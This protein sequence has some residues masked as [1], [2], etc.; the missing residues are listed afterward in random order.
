MAPEL[1]H[2]IPKQALPSTSPKKGGGAPTGAPTIGC[3]T[4]ADVAICQCCGRGRGLSGDRSPLGAPPRRLPR[5]LMPWLSPGRASRETAGKGVTFA[6]NRGYSDAPRA[7]VIMP[8]GSMPGPPGSGVTSPAR[9]NRTRPI[10]RLSPVDD[11]SMGEIRCALVTE[12]GTDV[13]RGSHGIRDS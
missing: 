12:V 6:M 11:P 2:A 7:P 13:K 4:L 5:K 9:R 8:A 10:N 3:A 1:C